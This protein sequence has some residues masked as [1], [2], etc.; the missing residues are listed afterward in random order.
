MASNPLPLL[1][2]AAPDTAVSADFPSMY[3]G[4]P[5]TQ[6]VLGIDNADDDTL[7]ATITAGAPYFSVSAIDVCNWVDVPVKS[8]EPI[9][10]TSR[11]VVLGFPS[12]L[13][14][15]VLQRQLS[16][17][18]A[19][20]DGT[21]PLAVAKGQHA[22]LWVT[23]VVPKG[24]SLSPGKF[25]GSA[26]LSGKTLNNRVSLLGSYLGNLIGRVNV[27]PATVVPGQSVLV[28]VLDSSG[29]VIADP[30]VTVMI[31]GV[32]S[33]SRYYQFPTTGTRTLL[34]SATR[35]A[36]NET[37]R[38]NV[39]VTGTPL[40]FRT[41]LSLPAVTSIPMLQA[42]ATTGQPYLA[43]FS[44]GPSPGVRRFLAAAPTT[45]AG[46]PT[47]PAASISPDALGSEL[48]KAFAALPADQV[49]TIAPTTTKT[50]AATATASAALA[51]IGNLKSLPTATSYEWDFGDGQ[52]ATTQSPNVTHDYFPAILA[53]KVAHAFDVTC[54]I[55]HDNVTVKRT[56]VLHSA[57]GLCRQLG[58]VVPPVTGLAYATF[59]DVA[60][61]ATLIVH[62]LEPQ[63]LQLS[64]MAC[65]PISDDVTIAPP[66]PSFTAMRNPIMVAASAASA[67]G[68]YVPVSKLQLGNAKV[69]GFIVHYRGQMTDAT[70]AVVPVRF[71]Y[72]FRIPLSDSGLPNVRLPVQYGPANWA[73]ADALQ[74]VSALATQTGSAVSKTGGQMID[75]ATNTVAIALSADPHDPKTLMQVGSAVAAGM[76]SI[77]VKAG[78]VD[79]PGIP[80]AL[81]SPLRASL[82]STTPKM[83]SVTQ[84][85]TVFRAPPSAPP[86]LPQTPSP[87]QLDVRFDPL[88]PPAVQAGNECYPDDISDA[89]AATAS[90]QQ[91]VCQLTSETITETISGAFQNALAGDVILSPAP[92]GGGDLIAAMFSALVP[93]Q[94]H[95][96][97]GIMTANF[98]ELTHCTASVDRI[99][100]NVIKDSVGLPSSLN[101]E[102]LQYGW[103]GSLTQSVDD[104]TSQVYLKDPGGTSYPLDSFNTSNEGDGFEII[105]PLV[106]K[107]LPENE[108]TV[109]PQL[110]KAADTA[111]S[112]GAKYD[113]GGNL[114]QPA[115]CYYSFYAYTNP[116]LSA[117]FG[118]PAGADAGWAAGMSPAVCSSFVWMCLKSQ[119]IPLVTGN[120]YEKLSDFSA[121]AVAGGAEVGSA[122]LDGL[123]YYPAAER[124]QAAN[125][126]YQMFM[127]QALSQ[128]S[129]LGTIPGI[130]GALAGPIADQLLNTFASGNPN[131]VGSDAW[132]S[133][134]DGNAVSPDNIIWWNPP[135]FGYAEPLQYLPSHTELYTVSKWTKVITWGSIKGVVRY[136]GAPVANAHVWVFLPG[137]DTYTAADG[138]YTLDHIP[139]GPYELKAQ[140]VIATN[141]VSEEYTNGAGGQQ[142]TLSAATSM[143]SQDINLQGL[144]VNYRRADVTYSISCDHGDGNPFN[145]HGVQ[146]QG[147]FSQSTFLNPG[148]VTNRLTYSYDYN[149]GGYF[150]VDYTFSVALLQDL[151]LE[152]T[153]TGEMY[154]DGD[155]NVQDQYTVGP[156]NVAVGGT[157]SG[158][159][160]MESTGT[161][162]HN[163]P[164]HLTFSVSNNQ[165]TG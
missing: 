92:V 144:P 84:L 10:T 52:K 100:D 40:G 119:N 98:Y 21:K 20:S 121:A 50:G 4:S 1:Q 63:A 2:A 90:A 111:R 67:L 30:G 61:S 6:L 85:G 19:S 164:A 3:Y 108:A 117:G 130:N 26:L 128:E 165:Q 134:G 11:S 27:Q 59:H 163:G 29:K 48:S 38:A 96:H 57:Y 154:N 34:I 93:P 142:I 113:A 109:R 137:G 35:G 94:H 28:Q 120:E 17:P 8:P 124:L 123:I 115:G 99:K 116:Q 86:V 125:A 160:D 79:S 83:G 97:S 46:T 159:M 158:W 76:T 139:I 73:I 129:G 13:K 5:V 110:R 136:G 42:A 60:F 105:P 150:H 12:P 112:K 25:S 89:D 70:G 103:P 22:R 95:G 64:A 132:T 32:E 82:T 122:T 107:P 141:G 87:S 15:P 51:A 56:L 66:A 18:V 88:S 151:S 24:A 157:W 102:M 54:T 62:N 135:Y 101:P 45:G 9:D 44:V 74:A 140:A 47:A 7:T 114:V 43:S 71:S 148:L 69:N 131:L 133:P 126:L 36:M 91:L 127:D 146:S 81:N 41:S 37:A 152:V 23:A 145:A 14:P 75:P 118:D 149:G 162:Y 106:V 39:V 80:A 68:I 53:G 16:A 153:L 155:N 55:V 161:G 78:A 33:A 138:S 72:V 49:I 156:F 147:P 77:A 65:V 58:T 143:L 31:Q 104:A